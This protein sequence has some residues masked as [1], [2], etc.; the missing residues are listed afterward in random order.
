MLGAGDINRTIGRLANLCQDGSF[1]LDRLVQ[2]YP[3]DRLSEALADQATGLVIKPVVLAPAISGAP[4]Q[5]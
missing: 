3:S 2:V 4:N 1:P 5:L